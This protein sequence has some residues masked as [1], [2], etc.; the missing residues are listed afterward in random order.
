MR[1]MV[2]NNIVKQD[3]PKITDGKIQSV[4]DANINP[5][6]S[7]L[8]DKISEIENKYNDAMFIINE[9]KLRIQKIEKRPNIFKR[10]LI[11]LKVLK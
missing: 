7:D 5:R 11:F 3:K 2:S 8:I 4:L 10:I 6:I 1:V 9:L